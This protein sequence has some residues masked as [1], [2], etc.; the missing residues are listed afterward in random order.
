[1]GQ[2]SDKEWYL[3]LSK[4]YIEQYGDVP[5]PWVYAPTYHPYSMGWRMGGGETHS[6][7]MSEWLEQQD[8]SEEQRI[9]YMKKYPAPPRWLTWVADF[10]WDLD[11]IDPE[12]FDY[13]P[14][15]TKLEQLGFKGTSDF[16]KD[17]N[18]DEWE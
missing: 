9:A 1:M 15:F 4:E 18:S 7:V 14:Y 13:E 10:I 8:F 16:E 17:F 12:D 5:P 3:K 11:P 2:Y 6:M